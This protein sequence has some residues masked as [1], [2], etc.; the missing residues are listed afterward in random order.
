MKLYTKIA[1]ALVLSLALVGCSS[2]QSEPQTEDTTDE[3]TQIPELDSLIQFQD[4]YPDDMQVAIMNTDQGEIDFVLFADQAP[5]AVEN[6]V[7]HAKEGYYNGVTF[8]RVIDDFMIQTGDPTGTGSGGESIWGEPFED[9]FSYELYI[10]R[11][12]VSMANSGEDTN[13]SQFFIV[14]ADTMDQELNG[15]PTLAEEKYHEVG[16]TPWLDQVHTVFGQVISGM[17]VVDAIADLEDTDITAVINTIEI[18]TYK[19]YK[20]TH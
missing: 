17:D 11:G 15:W 13:G 5:K 8:H 1:S 9:E 4:S 20:E 18:T 2:T 14:Q 3:T 10:F 6:F 12:A 7:T 16:G 19:E